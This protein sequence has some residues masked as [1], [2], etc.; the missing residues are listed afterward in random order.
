VRPRRA[1]IALLA[2][3]AALCGHVPAAALA[4]SGPSAG[5][6]Q[7]VDPL[8]GTGTSTTAHHAKPAPSTSTPVPGATSTLSDSSPLTSSGPPATAAGSD[9]ATL[10]VTGDDALLVG[11]L[12]FA[13]A[14]A[15]VAARRATRPG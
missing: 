4:D 13:L 10:P 8:A 9:P 7:Y 1:S 15:G 5:D 6:N 12:G 11:V 3:C 2:A 14:G